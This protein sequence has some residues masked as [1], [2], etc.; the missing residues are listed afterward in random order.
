MLA[1][2]VSCNPGSEN[3]QEAPTSSN[4]KP[5][6]VFTLRKPVSDKLV[7]YNDSIRFELE[8]GRQVEIDSLAIF[9]EGAKVYSTL[10]PSWAFTANGLFNRVGRQTM[11]IRLFYNEGTSQTLTCRIVVLSDTPPKTYQFKVLR[12]LPHNTGDFTQGLV[13]HKGYLYEGTGREYHSRIIKTDPSNGNTLLERKLD[14]RFFGE[15][16]TVVDDKLYQLTYRHKVGFVYDLESFELL[17]EFELQTMEGWGLT[18]DGENLI[19]SDGSS[20]LYFYD[21][22]YI[23]Q[24]RQLDVANNTGL[25]NNLNELEYVEGSIWANVY[26]RNIVVRIDPATGKVTGQLDLEELYP[27]DIPRDYDHVLNGIAYNPVSGTYFVTGKLWPV[28]YEIRI[29]E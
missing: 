22:E 19:L 9:I 3:V 4:A 26:T 21:P 25:V 28:M 2:A 6:R 18:Y 1:A 24:V 29:F 12:T 15:G 16:I 27:R 23:R 20:Y 10:S 13:Y 5:G 7:Y 8:A 11:R 17:R 14:N